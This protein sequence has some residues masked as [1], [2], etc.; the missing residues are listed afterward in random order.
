MHLQKV[1][2]PGRGVIVS[3]QLAV[4]WDLLEET[5]ECTLLFCLLSR[6]LEGIYLSSSDLLNAVT[7]LYPIC[8]LSQRIPC[9]VGFWVSLW[10]KWVHNLGML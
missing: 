2:E 6:I 7:I 4:L 1:S 8:M 5:V 3:P 10:A 9:E